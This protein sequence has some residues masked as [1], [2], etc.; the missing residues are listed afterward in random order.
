MK[1]CIVCKTPIAQGLEIVTETGCVH[2]G[3]CNA[4]HEELVN[5]LQEGESESDLLEES[6][7]LL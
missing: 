3:Q 4:Y 6:Q 2:M 7:L 5:S 1:V